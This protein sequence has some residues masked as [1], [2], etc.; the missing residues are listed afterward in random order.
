M[1]VLLSPKQITHTHKHTQQQVRVSHIYTIIQKK[2]VQTRSAKRRREP[3]PSTRLLF[4]KATLS[5]ASFPSS[6]NASALAHF[7]ATNF[8]VPSKT[9]Q[10]VRINTQQ[11]REHLQRD[12]EDAGGCSQLSEKFLSCRCVNRMRVAHG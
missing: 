1:A 4:K 11:A 8:V 12:I 7:G 9:N 6:S 3:R 10:W 5:V 2:Y